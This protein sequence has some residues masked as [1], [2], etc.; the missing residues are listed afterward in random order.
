MRINVRKVYRGK[1]EVFISEYQEFCDRIIDLVVDNVPIDELDTYCRRNYYQDED[2]TLSLTCTVSSMR[3]NLRNIFSI[4]NISRLEDVIKHYD[5]TKGI[6]MIEDYQRLLDRYLSELR[7]R[8][9]SG[10]SKDIVNAKTIV[11]ILDWASDDTPF[12]SIKRLLY[13]AFIYLNKNIIL[14]KDTGK[15]ILHLLNIYHNTVAFQLLHVSCYGY[16]NLIFVSSFTHTHTHTRTHTRTHTHTHTTMSAFHCC[17][18][19]YN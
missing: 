12:F 1:F 6:E 14:A 7:V 13:K 3:G 10:S 5:I 8:C 9:L 18:M 4:T 11:F 16:F 19:W 17:S 15:K 2:V